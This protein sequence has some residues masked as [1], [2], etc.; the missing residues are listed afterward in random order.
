LASEAAFERCGEACLL[1][2]VRAVAVSVGVGEG[3]AVVIGLASL[4]GRSKR[5][6]LFF[7]VRGGVPRSLWRE[8]R[9]A[10]GE[11]SESDEG[12]SAARH[13]ATEL[14]RSP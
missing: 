11:G 7:G 2:T 9:T 14:S 4:D 6:D 10:A 1:V 5:R 3:F 8:R 12:L 13:E